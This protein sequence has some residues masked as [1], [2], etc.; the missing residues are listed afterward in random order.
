LYLALAAIVIDVTVVFWGGGW[1]FKEFFWGGCLFEKEME[2]ENEGWTV[3]VRGLDGWFAGWLPGD[4]SI[5]AVSSCQMLR[6]LRMH[7]PNF[8]TH[9]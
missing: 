8:G 5:V 6:A 3:G 9:V 7:F 4:T 1:L 2:E